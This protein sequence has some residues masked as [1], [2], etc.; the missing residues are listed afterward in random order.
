MPSFLHHA[1]KLVTQNLSGPFE[2][3]ADIPRFLI[4]RI[5]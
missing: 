1:C 5:Y 4:K 2:E 3:Q